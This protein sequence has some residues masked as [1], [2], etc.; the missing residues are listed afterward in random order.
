MPP[1]QPL[2]CEMCLYSGVTQELPCF[3][4]QLPGLWVDWPNELAGKLGQGGTEGGG[5]GDIPYF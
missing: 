4:L 2:P 5:G 1:L 3:R